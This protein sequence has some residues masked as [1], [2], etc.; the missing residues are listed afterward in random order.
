M[1]GR[2]VKALSAVFPERGYRTSGEGIVMVI[3]FTFIKKQL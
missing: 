3:P 1:N 2:I